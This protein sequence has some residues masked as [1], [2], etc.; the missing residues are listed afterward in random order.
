MYTYMY[1]FWI[2]SNMA[3][4]RG[5]NSSGESGLFLMSDDLRLQLG[6]LADA[7]VKSDNHSRTHSHTDGGFN[8]ARWQPARQEQ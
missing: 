1:G 3:F 8:H 5:F 6:P 4:S 2:I 7:F